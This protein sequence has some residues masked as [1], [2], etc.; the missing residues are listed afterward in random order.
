MKSALGLYFG[1]DNGCFVWDNGCFVWDI[2][3]RGQGWPRVGDRFL[4]RFEVF[5]AVW[6][7]RYV[8]FT[9]SADGVVL[10]TSDVT[11]SQYASSA[12]CRH[13]HTLP[14]PHDYLRLL[15][16]TQGL[17]LPIPFG[18]FPPES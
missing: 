18:P 17:H 6:V 14:G 1:I 11:R 12:A 9:H 10:L 3:I 2:A 7:C 5:R 4:V 16:H 8:D 15:L 13:S